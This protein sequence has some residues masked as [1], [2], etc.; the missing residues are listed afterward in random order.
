MPSTNASRSSESDLFGKDD[1]EFL[2]ALGKVEIPDD[3]P[4]PPELRKEITLSSDLFGTEDSDFLEALSRTD[5][6]GDAV[7][8]HP[9]TITG[10]TMKETANLTTGKRKR[11]ASSIDIE[12][13]SPSLA[14]IIGASTDITPT[15]TDIYGPSKFGDF[16][17]YMHRK[18][19]KLSIQ[20]NE[21]EDST[22]EKSTLF[23]GLALYV[24]GK[25]TPSVQELRKLIVKH[26][27]I[28]HPYLDRKKMVTHIIAS[29]L[30]PSKVLEFK[31]MRVVTPEWL[32]ESIE[33]GSVLPWRNFIIGAADRPD[34]SQGVVKA[35][36][37]L[38]RE[39]L[40]ENENV[41]RTEPTPTTS[42]SSKS[43]PNKQPAYSADPVIKGEASRIPSYASHDSNPYAKRKMEDPQWRAENTAVAPGF[44]E[45]YYR[46]SRLHHLSTWKTELQDLVAKAVERVENAEER[47]EFDLDSLKGTTSGT[48]MSGVQFRR[49]GSPRKGKSAKPV[50]QTIMHC[51]FDSF[52]VSAGLVDRPHLKGKAVV[53]C[54]SQDGQGGGSSTSEI[55]SSSYE[56]RKFGVK[57]G[58]SLGQA[59]KLCPDLYTIPYEF[60]QYKR[61]SLQFYTILMS[62]ADDLQAVSV[63][64]ALVDVSSTVENA[65]RAA[66]ADQDTDFAKELAE[67]I[68]TKVRN[69]T[70]CEVSIGIS[71]N[72]LLARVATRR[73]KPAGSYH[74]L[75]ENVF[76]IL[77]PLDIEDLRGFGWSTKSKL[78]AKFGVTTLGELV[79]RPKGALCDA[80]GKK[81]G[82]TLWK[83]VRGIDDT[84][85]ESD[86]VRKSV[87]CE[88]NY[89]IRFENDGEVE[90]F[91][92]GV[93]TEVS[94][95]L[96][97]IEM[98]GR[99]LT[100][101][102]MT[103]D[104][105][106][107]V[108]AAKF[109]G[110]GM[111]NITNKTAPFAGL[112]GRSTA[113]PAVIGQC[114]WRLLK[115]MHIDPRE[116]RGVGIHVQKLEKT[117]RN[118]PAGDQ[119]VLSF[120]LSGDVIKETPQIEGEEADT[121]PVVV[122]DPPSQDALGDFILPQNDNQHLKPDSA[123]VALPSFSQIDLSVLE[124]LPADIRAELEREYANADSGQPVA[125]PSRQPD[126]QPEAVVK[127]KPPQA[128]LGNYPLADIARITR[129]LAPKSSSIS[130][131]KR[132]HPLFVKRTAPSGIKVGLSEL[133]LFNIDQEVWDELPIELQREQLA[134]LRAAN[135]GTG[136]AIRASMST[137][138]KRERILMRW[139]TR[140]RSPS[141]GIRG[142]RLEIFAKG[143]ELPTL[144]QRG[145]IKS[146]EMRVSETDD[147]QA[148]IS[149][150]VEGFEEDGPRQGDVEY[151]GKFLTRCVET[152][153]GAE[154][155][156]SAMKWWR[157]LLRQRWAQ[158]EG[159]CSIGR[160]T[161][162]VE[163][164]AGRAWWYAFWEVKKRM[165]EVVKKQYGGRLSLK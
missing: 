14:H 36:Q 1:S 110:H 127:D 80:L 85:I 59:R 91:V 15:Q 145:K 29:N 25:T 151:F 30:T 53:V 64:E 58:M 55:A 159:T 23:Q 26:G 22:V 113:D 50:R 72:I 10:V 139:R 82:E 75:P 121:H 60:E 155:G 42:G 73:A 20:N 17:E 24:N 33:A 6:P 140:G 120:K 31:N 76:E 79:K 87:S 129:Q 153:V 56:A 21:I 63:D 69:A 136:M 92:H 94:D 46:N 156:V 99:S 157:I 74:I 44:I 112:D 16:G 95:R 65:R 28:F 27:G 12:E 54:H 2:E 122:V 134:A 43:P 161:T 67:V 144:K 109:L 77:A 119:S 45:G 152:D 102:V 135:V 39:P 141:V 125:G 4:L 126:A 71:H 107:P 41:S 154:R 100:L 47:E 138:A 132:L 19:A 114:A 98:R 150:W 90:K 83:A 86:R 78:E 96:K 11:S 13:P 35:T 130:P 89:G 118:A 115:G 123:P 84:K 124:A 70:K 88:I 143:L 61:F 147:I 162:D 7:Q 9:T 149:Q 103:R 165:D 163:G 105:K 32:L 97:K 52:F 48:S 93:A 128:P 158:I 5:L 81:T 116:L 34:V 8:P 38:N 131:S 106:A 148:I 160:G 51:D 164:E 3:T 62:Y 18:R 49:P 104:P 68:R 37:L 117:T 57:N 133:K 66:P 137:Q 146:E 111:C 40:L 108:E 142:Q 101:K